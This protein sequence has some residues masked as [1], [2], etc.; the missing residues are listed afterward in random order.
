MG[1]FWGSSN[2]G[3]SPDS[4]DNDPLRKLDPSLRDFLEKESPVKYTSFKPADPLPPKT[5]ESRQSYHD[6][7]S[8]T[9]QPSPSAQNITSASTSSRTSE[10]SVPRESLYQDGRYA[11]IWKN[12]QPL[13]DVEAS[14]K[15]DQDKLLDVLEGY[16]H[17]KAEIGRAALENCAIEQWE[18][19]DCFRNG[20]WKARA[21]MCRAEN[22]E[23]ERCYMMQSK[24]LKALGY[25]STFDRP[26]AVDEQIQM[27]ADTLYHRMLDQE[28]AIQT[29]K[30]AGQPL[31]TFPTIIPTPAS[32]LSSSLS[33]KSTTATAADGARITADQLTP[34][35]QAMLKKRLSGLGPEER[36]VEEKAI[37]AEIAA[38]ER[39]GRQIG[40]IYEE[41][42]KI[43]RERRET[44]RETVADRIG[45]WFGW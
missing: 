1:W 3:D 41:Q 14:G 27:H 18:V 35:V 29:A 37:V 39:L 44:G 33:P 16:K 32:S 38:G 7:I 10:P 13:S 42:E 40:N 22:K 9:S 11:H 21:T 20:G 24:F 26:P 4:G 36:E 17:R 2:S 30:A 19:N 23:L 43:K 12:Y 8:T 45:G 5:L 31:P 25:L 6:R 15:S 34:E 28:K